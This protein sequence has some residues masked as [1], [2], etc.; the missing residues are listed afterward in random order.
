MKNQL[1]KRAGFFYCRIQLIS[2]H[3]AAIYFALFFID[4][5]LETKLRFT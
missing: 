4:I 1:F 3:G 2:K 5:P